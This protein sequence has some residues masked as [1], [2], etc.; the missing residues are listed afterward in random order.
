M[1][2][3]TATFMLG[4]LVGIFLASSLTRLIAVIFQGSSI[5]SKKIVCESCGAP[6][7]FL[8]RIPIVA[9]FRSPEK[10]PVCAH[11]LPRF[12]AYME[13]L[14]FGFSIWA[15]TA[16]GAILALQIS[17]LFFALIGVAYMDLKKWIIPNEFVVTILAVGILGLAA[18]TVN[19]SHALLGLV[20]AAAVSL[21][22]ILPQRFG[23]GDRT[24]ALGDVKLCLAVS[25]WLGWV[26]SAYVFF[27]ASILA[28]MTWLIIAIF[29]GFS[30]Q[31]RVPFGPFVALTTLLFGIGRVLDPQ[32]VTH[33]LT[34]RF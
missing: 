26:L 9:A 11:E 1:I 18:G 24:L 12:Y 34:F 16:M 15:F 3:S 27:F 8:H 13:M 19:F 29:R 2:P 25:L 30:I 14:I 21:L 22:I 20:L 31:R 10:C 32:F 4:V 5:V 33:L 28:F 7:P 6:H 17:V 23:S